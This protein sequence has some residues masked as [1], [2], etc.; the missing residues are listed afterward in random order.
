M[1][2]KKAADHNW[3]SEKTVSNVQIHCL[4]NS[5]TVFSAAFSAGS[6]ADAIAGLRHAAR[7][8]LRYH[9]NGKKKT[10]TPGHGIRLC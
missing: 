1:D 10:G 8:V 7:R 3:V 4:E 9:R 6:A 5:L 2:R